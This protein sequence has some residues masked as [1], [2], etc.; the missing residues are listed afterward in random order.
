[1]QVGFIS[2]PRKINYLS[3]TLSSYFR[4]FKEK[5]T[6][7]EEPGWGNYEN[8]DKV[9][10]H[11]NPE[12]LGLVANWANAACFMRLVPDDFYMLCED[13]I[14]FSRGCGHKIREYLKILNP[15]IPI[16]VS[17]YCSVI[18]QPETTGWSKP[19]KQ[20]NWCGALCTIM[21]RKAIELVQQ[22]FILMQSMAPYHSHALGEE[23][24]VTEQPTHLDHAIG[25]TF[26]NFFVHN[27]TL[28]FHT[29]LVSASGK[30]QPS[31]VRSRMPAI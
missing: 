5:P 13:D 8:H 28:I 16:A 19:R 12:R 6:V 23:I 18:N 2:A 24:D 27:P 21:N 29:G 17:P 1:M 11:I 4:E 10:R 3:D 15:N 25:E 20:C 7:Y 14:Q 30:E 26:N 9:I 22:S 31:Y